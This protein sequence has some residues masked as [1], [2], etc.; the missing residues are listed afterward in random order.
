MKKINFLILAY[1]LLVLIMFVLPFYS[2][3]TYNIFR[4]TTS[5]LGAQKT[6][7]SWIMNAG[8]ILIGTTTIY[9]GWKSLGKLYY[10][11]LLVVVFGL[12]LILVAIFQH[13]PI[14]ENIEYSENEDKLH[15][16]FATLTGVSFT[17]IAI[18]AGFMEHKHKR[19][20]AISTGVFVTMMSLLMSYVSNYM[21]LWQRLIFL[22]AFPWLNYFFIGLKKPRA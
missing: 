11:K 14:I 16:L 17:F 9:E 1:I 12:S 20:L 15:S 5:H 21:G 4:N 3:D 2:A 18:S 22:A 13:A 8:F 7:N 10:F 19:I 6:R